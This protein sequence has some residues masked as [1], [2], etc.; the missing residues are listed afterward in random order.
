ML[1][2]FILDLKP[3]PDDVKPS[4]TVGRE[5]KPVL[6]ETGTFVRQVVNEQ[7]GLETVRWLPSSQGKAIFPAQQFRCIR[8]AAAAGSCPCPLFAG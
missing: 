4:A 6:V 5:I 2:T 1:A 8:R 3:N 7:S